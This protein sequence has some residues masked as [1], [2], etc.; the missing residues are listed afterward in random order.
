MTLSDLTDKK[1]NLFKI[2]HQTKIIQWNSI[3]TRRKNFNIHFFILQISAQYILTETC[4][5]LD[6][7]P[8]TGIM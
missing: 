7:V 8:S 5:V 4:P 3:I 2:G 1:N 6:S